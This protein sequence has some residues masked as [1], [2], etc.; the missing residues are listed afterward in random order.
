MYGMLDQNRYMQGA[1]RENT[2]SI[3]INYITY[4]A[5]NNHIAITGL[6][7]RN[8]VCNV[9]CAYYI[10]IPILWEISGLFYASII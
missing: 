9:Q 10:L 5:Y 6:S 1:D 8:T 7:D 3:Y 4:M 2:S